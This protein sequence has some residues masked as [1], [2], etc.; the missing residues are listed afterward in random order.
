MLRQQVTLIG[1][2]KLCRWRDYNGL[3]PE[4]IGEIKVVR[5]VKDSKADERKKATSPQLLTR[6]MLWAGFTV[7]AKYLLVFCCCYCQGFVLIIT[8]SYRICE[9]SQAKLLLTNIVYRL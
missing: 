4:A 5:L 1:T 2:E 6:E 8:Y 3:L 7:R 9:F